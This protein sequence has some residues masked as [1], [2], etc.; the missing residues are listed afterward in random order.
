[1]ARVTDSIDHLALTR[2]VEAQAVRGADVVGQPGGWGIVIKYGMVER[3]LVT[4]SGSL[5]LFKRFD[6]L[7][8]YLKDMGIAKYVVDA[9]NYDPTVARSTIVRPD[10]SR[11]LK[12]AFQALEQISNHVQSDRCT[13]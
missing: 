11:R 7:V 3:P 9:S 10:A 8:A 4:R 13:R 5:R 1:M 2:L 12:Q 6:S